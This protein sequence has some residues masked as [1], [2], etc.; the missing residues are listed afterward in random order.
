MLHAVEQH[1]PWASAAAYAS[2]LSAPLLGAAI[3]DGNALNSEAGIQL[4][5]SGLRVGH[6]AVD[7]G[8]GTGARLS[9]RVRFE[10]ERAALDRAGGKVGWACGC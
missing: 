3:N 5:A 9:R 8:E 2:A 6:A 4:P 10:A 1:G 7:G